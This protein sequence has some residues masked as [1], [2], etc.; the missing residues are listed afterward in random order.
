MIRSLRPLLAALL[1]LTAGALLPSGSVG[2]QQVPVVQRPPRDPAAQSVEVV[3]APVPTVGG[4]MRGLA[5]DQR[6]LT[7]TADVPL[8]ERA[9]RLAARVAV[10]LPTGDQVVTRLSHYT[11]RPDGFF[12]AGAL[13]PEAGQAEGRGEA[14]FTV[15]DGRLLGRVV[16]KGRLFILRE[17]DDPGLYDVTEATAQQFPAEQ[18]PRGARRP[19][20]GLD[21]R[22]RASLGDAAVTVGHDS[23]QQI[24]VLVIYTAAAR[25]AIGGTQNMSL[26][27]AGAIDNGNLALANSGLSQ[28]FRLVHQEETSYIEVGAQ[29]LDRLADPDDGFMDDVHVLRDRYRADVVTLVATTNACGVGYLMTAGSISVAAFQDSAFNVAHWSCIYGNLTMAHE[30][31]HNIGLHH[32]RTNASQ[33]AAYPY[34]YG[35]RIPGS[36]SVMAYNCTYGNPGFSCATRRAIFSTPAQL[37]PGTAS[38][39]GV[40]NSE[41]NALAISNTSS[42]VANFRDSTCAY[43]LTTSGASAPSAGD[44][45]TLTVTTGATCAWTAV[46]SD[47]SIVTLSAE[48]TYTGSRTIAFTVAANGGA[49]R[50]AL[51][52]AGGQSVTITQ[53]GPSSSTLTPSP[54]ALTLAATR[55]GA[56]DPL[57]SVTGPETV[58]LVSDGPALAT[59]TATSNQPW[60]RITNGTGSGSGAFVVSVVDSGNALLG[61]NS[62][63]AAIT[64][65]ATAAANAPLTIP[66]SL[67]IDVVAAPDGAPFGAVDT[68]TDGATGVAGAVAVTGWALDDVGV[69]RVEIWRDCLEAIDRGRGACVSPAPGVPDNFVFIGRAAFLSGARP[70]VEAAY[71]ALPMAS[72]AG[73]G[74]LLL[75]TGLPHQP[76]GAP[77]GGQ[78]T[79]TVTAYAVDQEHHYAQL[80]SRTITL[81]NDGATRPF[82]AIDTP[83]QGETITAPLTANF[84]WAM[85]QAPKC[86]A[87]TRYRVFIDG[88][89]RMLTPGTNWFP[90]LSRPDLAAAYPSLCDSANPLA[91]YY[92]D[93]PALGLSNGLHTI[94]WDVFDDNATPGT[95][96]DDNVAGIG[97]RFFS[98]LIGS[99]DVGADRRALEYGRPVAVGAVADLA[100]LAPLP[101]GRTDVSLKIGGR[102]Q[103]DLGGAVDAGYEIVGSERRALPTGSTL[104]AAA[105]IFSWAPPIP[106]GGSFDLVFVR[107]AQRVDVRVSMVDPTAPI[108]TTVTVTSPRPGANPNPYIRVEG[109][110]FDPHAPMGSGVAAV[111]VWAYRIDVPGVAPQFL[112]AADLR[113][114]HFL[115]DAPVLAPGSYDLAV[116]A[117]NT[118]LGQWAP[119]SVVAVAVR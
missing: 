70:D 71:S 13:L 27:I 28:R 15:Q 21:R 17:S 33:Q 77:V 32:D 46:S 86:I 49:A 19:G 37:F 96:A 30:I 67:S 36:R 57:Q 118:Q 69:D 105:G 2:A 92:I 110:A 91:A 76:Q 51:I 107:Q 106:Y 22:Q 14:T 81:D 103:L 24:D 29:D 6:R 8:M 48:P 98:V 1:A 5:A 23:G 59:W 74:Y 56:T 79:V 35:Y 90:D 115:L 82:G 78:G 40:L 45:G 52:D 112:G 83:G 9:A 94:G 3:F 10:P 31:G 89:A 42:V 66:V 80:G 62:A 44:A 111:H 58:T 34:A 87:R 68:P 25:A 101:S 26:E 50:S 61:A 114:R 116:F 73:W 63:T 54:A 72:R 84:G 53:A 12:A 102:V 100:G 55:V 18:Q 85:T 47:P 88:V 4:G 41:D 97:S 65:T 11:S 75:T 39:A 109:E 113:G 64:V 16:S 38:P 20:S 7:V 104:D 93:V 117:W 99:T 119:A 95:P 60:L 108:T 43:A